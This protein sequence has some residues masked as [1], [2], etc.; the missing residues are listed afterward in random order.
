[1]GCWSEWRDAAH[2]E[3]NR[4]PL[5]WLDACT[6]S[7]Y[8]HSF[9]WGIL[10][11]ICHLWLPFCANNRNK[12]TSCY[13]SAASESTWSPSQCGLDDSSQKELGSDCILEH[14]GQTWCSVW[15]SACLCPLC[16]NRRRFVY[17][18]NGCPSDWSWRDAALLLCLF[19][20]DIDCCV[21][22]ILG[23]RRG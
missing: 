6:A 13:F 10:F 18:R 16:M 17:F 19:K 15:F 7:Y 3:A 11:L 2:L 22:G 9:Q 1:M 20:A 23:G 21:G 12:F 8:W 4:S 5:H 14:V